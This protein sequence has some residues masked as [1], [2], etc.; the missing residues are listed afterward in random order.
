M[1]RP[2]AG[3]SRLDF[4]RQGQGQLFIAPLRLGTE[5]R[6]AGC[7]VSLGGGG[8]SAL[9]SRIPAS[10]WRNQLLQELVDRFLVS[11]FANN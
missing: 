9:C 10:V 1:A 8:D 11:N 4:L 5:G 3:H 7:G 6:R 2:A